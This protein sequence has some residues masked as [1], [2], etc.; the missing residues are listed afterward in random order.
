MKTTRKQ[1]KTTSTPDPTV[2]RVGCWHE[3]APIKTNSYRLLITEGDS[4]GPRFVGGECYADLA[5]TKPFV[6]F[7]DEADA[8]ACF[9][10]LPAGLTVE[11]HRWDGKH[12]RNTGAGVVPAK[13]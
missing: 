9:V 7:T 3:D 5:T 12:W 8:R 11:Y 13:G 6:V 2:Y 10:T 4:F 1:T